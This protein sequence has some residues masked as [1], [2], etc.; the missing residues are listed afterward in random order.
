[1]EYDQDKVDEMVLAL[2]CLTMFE[3]DQDGA[4]AWK[5]YDWVAMDRLHAKGYVSDPKSKAKSVVV[6][7]KGR[8]P[9]SCSRNTSARKNRTRVS[10]RLRGDRNRA[11]PKREESTGA[12]HGPSSPVPQKARNALRLR[13]A[14]GR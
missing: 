5:G 8:D 11:I 4:R 6:T 2:L 3:E 10:G 14:P 9:A 13:C 12:D 7:V 1:M